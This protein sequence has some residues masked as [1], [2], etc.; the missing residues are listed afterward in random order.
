M[1]INDYLNYEAEIDSDSEDFIKD[2]S[3]DEKEE[4]EEKK[5]EKEEKENIENKK[6]EY[7]EKCNYLLNEL[8]LTFDELYPLIDISLY[9]KL[10]D[11]HQQLNINVSKI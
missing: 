11:L 10:C 9:K 2:L 7:E 3:D 5:I 8:K 4:K 6:L 1:S